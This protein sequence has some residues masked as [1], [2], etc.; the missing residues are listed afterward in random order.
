MYSTL[1]AVQVIL[2]RIPSP[3]AIISIV[4]HIDNTHVCNSWDMYYIMCTSIWHLK[5]QCHYLWYFRQ[6]TPAQHFKIFPVWFQ[7]CFSKSPP[8]LRHRRVKLPGVLDTLVSSSLVSKTL[9]N[10]VPFSVSHCTIKLPS[11]Q[12]TAKSS[13]LFSKPSHS[14]APPCPIDCRVKLPRFQDTAESSS[15]VF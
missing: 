5:G 1:R 9:Q 7:F 6:W 4:F 12:D 3:L 11:V 10:Q 14:Q 2:W 15:P 13:S 8:H